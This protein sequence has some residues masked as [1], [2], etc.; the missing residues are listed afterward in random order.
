M[1]LFIFKNHNFIFIYFYARSVF[2]RTLNELE[3]RLILILGNSFRNLKQLRW[4]VENHN[5]AYLEV[6]GK[7]NSYLVIVDHK[8]SGLIRLNGKPYFELDRYHTLI[9]I[10][11]GSHK[12]SLELSNY[13]DFGEKVDISPGIPFYTEI[14]SNAYRLYIYGSQVLDLVRSINDNEVKEDLGN[15]LSKALREAYF[16]SISKEQ[17]FILSKLIRTTL[18]VSRM[19]Q[20]IEDP[21][22]VY[23]EDENRGKYE[24][25]LNILKSELSRLVSKYGKRG[26]LIGTGHAHIDTAWLWPFDETR[27]KVLR[28]FSTILTLLDKYDFHFI[29]SAAIYY[30]WIK[31]NSPE[32]F[33]RIKE[34]VKEGKWELAALY[35]ESDANMVSGESLAR[36]FLYSQRFYLENFG[37]IAD[38]LWLPDTFGFSASLPQ[39]AKLGGVKAFA[40]HKVFW[41]DTN[42]FPFNIFKWIAPNGEQLPAVTFGHGKGGYNSDFSA[43]SVLEQ[44]NNW[45]QKDQ[46]MLYSYGYGDGGGGP[47]EDMLIRAEAINLLP[48]LPKVELSGVNSY[49]RKI[50]PVE[51]WRG[52]LYLETHRGVLTSHSKMKLLNRMAEIALREAELWSTLARTY[53]KEVFTR[54]WKIVLKDQ[55]HDVLPGSAIKDVYKVTYQELEEVINTANNIASEAMLKLVG[56]RGD[57]TFVFN[58]LSWNREEYLEVN[59]KLVK[60][61]VPSVGF[62]LLEPVEV[63]DR[64]VISENNNEYLIE[65]KY[66][67]IRIGRNGEVL[68]LFDKEA[69]REVLGDKSNLLV[70]YENIPGWADAWDIEKGFEYTSFEIKA[71][72]SEILN[73]DGIVASIRF[74]Y[75]FRKSEIIQI[76]RVYADSRRIDFITTLRMKDRELLLKSWFY[77][78]LNVEKAVSDIP[79]GVIERFTWTNTS[80]DKARF[81][82]PNQK[83]VDFSESDYGVVLLNNGKYGATLRGS[84]VGLSLTKTPIYPDPSTDLEEITFVYSLY[85]HLGDWKK[86][87]VVKKAYELNVPL[88]VVNGIHEVKSKSFIKVSDKLILEA[89]KVAE[90]DSNSI[91]LRLYEYEN[92]RGEAII[93]LPFNVTEARSLDLLELNEVP[94]EIKTEGNRIRIK[95]KNRDILTIS[96][97][98]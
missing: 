52:E 8:G 73:N 26:E 27:R 37:R 70:A 84:S 51:E 58:S 93:E 71:S 15:A 57:K 95:Y 19:V 17:L 24:R 22:E 30:E 69:N 7:G 39:I 42:T 31:T 87:D 64:V 47:N 74:T 44:Y 96:V 5:K 38:I 80:W 50:V 86:A 23:K 75:K 98:G 45:V 6:E 40:T 66:Y 29:Q 83:F 90:D 46:P 48:I 55:F 33:E 85:P 3:A 1:N 10:P 59:G 28:T 4:N 78:D 81:E 14:D 76:I 91:V 60:V 65:N 11:F 79:F 89:V 53:D 56:G 21:L 34:K 72:S 77:F 67:K 20:E 36:Q 94:R 61:S 88:R 92:T 32:L 63:K 35:V 43:S 49:I 2:M 82:V 16:E 62:S 25:A 13:M 12:I 54:L 97:R 18:D 68:S 41:N 9:P